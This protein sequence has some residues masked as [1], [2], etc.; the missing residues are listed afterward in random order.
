MPVKARSG[1]RFICFSDGKRPN[2]PGWE[3]RQPG[4]PARLASPHDVNRFHK[5]FPHRLFPDQRW[6]IYIDGNIRF[7]GD[8]GRLVEIVR[9]TGAPVGAF[10]HPDGRNLIEEVE[11]CSRY[12]KFDAI[13]RAAAERQVALYRSEGLDVAAPISANYLL[14]RDHAY[15]GLDAAM[16]LWWSHL[17]EFSRRDQIGLQYSLYRNGLDWTTLDGPDGVDAALLTRLP[18]HRPWRQQAWNRTR[19]RIASVMRRA[20]P[21]RIS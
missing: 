20:R 17:F 18:H 14:V 12:G 21:A 5:V 15:P 1:L 8:W 13:D 9:R 10:R 3:F 4:S 16:S 2:A 6:S 19:K 11:A 7:A